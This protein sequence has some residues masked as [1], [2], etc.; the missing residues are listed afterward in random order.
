MH[1][2]FCAIYQNKKSDGTSFCCIFPAYF[3]IK[4]FS[5][6]ILYQLTKFQYQTFFSQDIKQYVVLNSCLAN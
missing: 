4:K 2:L 6:L 5:Y 3:S 1:W